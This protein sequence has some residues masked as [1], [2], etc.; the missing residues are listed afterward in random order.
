MADARSE[1]YA[2]KEIIRDRLQASLEDLDQMMFSARQNTSNSLMNELKTER[3]IVVIL[4]V[5]LIAMIILTAKLST[6]PLIHAA[7]NIRKREEIPVIGSREF[8]ELAEGYNE[9]FASI[10]AKASEKQKE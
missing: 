3:I 5:V 7:E 4:M 9:L 8:R 10:Q 1:Y 2:S 6:I